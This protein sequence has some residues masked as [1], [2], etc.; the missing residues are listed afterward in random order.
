MG[1]SQCV[2]AS[3]VAGPLAATKRWAQVK[4]TCKGGTPVRYWETH[5][6]EAG[7][8]PGDSVLV[9]LGSNDWGTVSEPAALLAKLKASRASCVWV[10][11]PLI[12]G[13]HGAA[14]KLKRDVTAE[15]TCSYL[16]SR[17]LNLIL[18]DGVHPATAAEHVRW[19]LAGIQLLP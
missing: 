10:G 11:P 17:D 4:A 7:I 19:L 14:P 2:G 12:R 13:K 8:M 15:G 9:Y 5:I 3:A 18:G 16:D 6:D 1:D